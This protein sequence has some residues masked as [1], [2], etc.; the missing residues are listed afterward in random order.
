MI[1]I[2]LNGED[3]REEERAPGDM[4]RS[5]WTGYCSEK[6]WRLGAE[7]VGSKRI[8]SGWSREV[9]PSKALQWG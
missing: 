9:K 2:Y 6:S 7:K 4:E 1:T 5:T 8:P 3:G